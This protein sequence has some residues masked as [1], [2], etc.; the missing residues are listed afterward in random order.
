MNQDDLQRMF[1]QKM[2]GGQQQSCLVRQPTVK[3]LDEFIDR[4]L[5]RDETLHTIAQSLQYTLQQAPMTTQPM[6]EIYP[7]VLQRIQQRLQK[8]EV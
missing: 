5:K 6:Q 2:S 8:G 4:C 3:E 1:Q 7:L